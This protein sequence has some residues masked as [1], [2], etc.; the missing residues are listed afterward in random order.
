[1]PVNKT[2]LN[3][4]KFIFLSA[5]FISLTIPSL[6][7][8]TGSENFVNALLDISGSFYEKEPTFTLS[9]TKG[10]FLLLL[11]YTPVVMFCY[12]LLQGVSMIN[13]LK[14]GEILSMKLADNMMRSALALIAIGLYLPVWRSLISYSLFLPDAHFQIS[15]SIGD[16]TL[17]LIG[18]M[19]SIAS[20]SVT[21]GVKADIENKEFI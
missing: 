4:M 8:L 15:L 5:I 2:K 6:V 7:L 10:L 18:W 14:N 20:K 13:D 19:L 17:V 3:C 16:L 9:G 1:M 11:T 21:L 12:F